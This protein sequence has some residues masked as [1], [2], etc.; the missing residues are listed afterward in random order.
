M[1]RYD[2]QALPLFVARLILG[3]VFIVAS[4]D[5]IAAPDAFAASIHAYRLTPAI[6]E[7]I[8]A[9]VIP[10]IELLCGICLVA[11]MNVRASS[12]LL[13]ILLG[14]F[15]IAIS[16]ALIRGLKIDCGCFGKEHLTPVSWGKVLEDVC[17]AGVG[18]YLII[19][20]AVK[21][22]EPGMPR[23]ERA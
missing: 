13:T 23:E 3:M 7:N 22:D 1:M 21:P 14:V 19:A 6:I 10:W 2:K 4:I 8:L 20:T 18:V 12:F 5:K 15:T 11:G 9:I 17:L 16:L